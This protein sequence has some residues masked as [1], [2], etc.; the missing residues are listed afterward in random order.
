MGELLLGA[1]IVYLP[2]IKPSYKTANDLTSLLGFVLILVSLIFINSKSTFPGIYS[3][4]P[5]LGTLLIIQSNSNSLVNR[6]ISHRV[7]VFFG[8]ISYSLYLWHWPIIVFYKYY[9]KVT[10]LSIYETL[11]LLSLLI[12]LSFLSLKLIEN[13]FRQEKVSTKNV[14]IYYF[15]IP[16][17]AIYAISGYISYKSG[18]PQRFGLTEEM[19]SVETIGCHDSLAEQTCYLSKQN[20]SKHKVLVIGDSHAGH[21]SNFFAKIGRKLGITFID[22]S[23][24][25]CK[26]FPK[27]LPAIIVK[28]LR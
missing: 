10:H 20:N 24:S 28:T 11:F 16:F 13:R 17:I 12:L 23:P 25:G 15:F 4:R 26:F 8:L 27:N 21:F 19:S 2:G 1:L 9:F 22:A 7:V 3:F 18:I 5:C 6:I 14:F